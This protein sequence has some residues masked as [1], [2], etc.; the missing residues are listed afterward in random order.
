[1][2]LNNNSK[3]INIITDE[4][5]IITSSGQENNSLSEI[6]KSHEENIDKLALPEVMP[7]YFM[8][9]KKSD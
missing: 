2:K 4:D 6:L 8:K 1:M 9:M 3:K 7:I 5:I